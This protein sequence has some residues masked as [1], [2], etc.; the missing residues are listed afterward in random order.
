MDMGNQ[1]EKRPGTFQV[2]RGASWQQ[3]A[4]SRDRGH[5]FITPGR[6]MEVTG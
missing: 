1:A 2:G 6:A 5:L 4:L 3:H